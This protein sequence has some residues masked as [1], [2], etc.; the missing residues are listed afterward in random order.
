MKMAVIYDTEQ[1]CEVLEETPHRV[2][3]RIFD[4]NHVVALEP[5]DVWI[6]T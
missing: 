5:G 6:L 3:V 4:D 2:L 1:L